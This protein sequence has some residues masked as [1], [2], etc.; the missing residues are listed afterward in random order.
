M[1]A[2]AVFAINLAHYSTP[3]KAVV[4]EKND[5][6]VASKWHLSVADSGVTEYLICSSLFNG[7]AGF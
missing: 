3:L 4:T 5:L 6:N 7:H 1:P 2:I